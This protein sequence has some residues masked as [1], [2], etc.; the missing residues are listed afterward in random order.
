MKLTGVSILFICVIAATFSNCFL[1]LAYNVNQSYIS[2]EL[3]V[4]KAIPSMHCKGHC[5]LNKQLEKEE[6]PSPLSTKGNEKFEIQLFCMQLSSFFINNEITE[7]SFCKHEQNFTPQQ[8][9]FN[10]FRPPQV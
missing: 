10:S 5:Y 4:N 2:K 3:C 6:K 9:V 7:K 8:F 1:I